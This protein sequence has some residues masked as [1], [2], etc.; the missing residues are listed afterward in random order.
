MFYL[1]WE[2]CTQTLCTL[3][4]KHYRYQ[5]W[6]EVL[7][8]PIHKLIS[9]VISAQATVYPKPIYHLKYIV[10]ILWQQL[11]PALARVMGLH[12]V[13]RPSLRSIGSLCPTILQGTTMSYTLREFWQRIK[14]NSSRQWKNIVMKY[15]QDEVLACQLSIQ[16]ITCE[17]LQFL[18]INVNT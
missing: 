5:E 14:I 15:Q 13:P 12:F 17:C 8:I 1:G 2:K 3:R 18:R 9:I 11:K 6:E 10:Y 4:D 7:V 16:G